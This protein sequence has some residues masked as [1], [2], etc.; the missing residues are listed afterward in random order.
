MEGGA[1]HWLLWVHLY[2]PNISWEQFLEEL[3]VR[4]GADAIVN[5]F[6]RLAAIKQM[7]SVDDF[8]NIFVTTAAQVPALSKPQYLGYFLNGL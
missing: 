6:E 7:G 2:N 8:I 1:L 4:Y 3:V 5:P